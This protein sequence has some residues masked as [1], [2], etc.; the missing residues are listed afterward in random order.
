MQ[1]ENVDQRIQQELEESV[2]RRK[3]M[4]TKEKYEGND[5]TYF[6][7]MGAISNGILWKDLISGQSRMFF[8]LEQSS[9]APQKMQA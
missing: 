5:L 3:K 4:K 1:R 9:Y 6:G 7:Q 8:R 2:M